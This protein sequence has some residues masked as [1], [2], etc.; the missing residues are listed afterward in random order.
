MALP[1]ESSGPRYSSENHPE[2]VL[3]N[4]GNQNAWSLHKR[5]SLVESSPA[6]GLDWVDMQRDWKRVFA[7]E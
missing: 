6:S 5:H 7:F 1:P 3:Q 2:V 4:T